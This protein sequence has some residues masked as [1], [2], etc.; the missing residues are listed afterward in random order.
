MKDN[1][2]LLKNIVLY[3]NRI[4]ECVSGFGRDEDEFM[5]NWRVQYICSFCVFQ[6]GENVK[7]LSK[8]LTKE[9]PEIKWREIAGTRDII[10]HGY[11]WIDLE[12]LWFSITEEVPTLRDTCERIMRES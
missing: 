12:T 8:E 4:E 11:E 3:C 10:A 2:H 5:N 6:I 1:T 9:Y 7:S